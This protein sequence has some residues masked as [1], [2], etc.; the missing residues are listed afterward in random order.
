MQFENVTY[1][2]IFQDSTKPRVVLTGIRAL[3]SFES[4]EL[5]KVEGLNG[6]EL[7]ERELDQWELLSNQGVSK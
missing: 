2:V 4:S 7:T 6:R 3:A 1:I 5:Y